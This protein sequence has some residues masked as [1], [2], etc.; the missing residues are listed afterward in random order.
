MGVG[1]YI[2]GYVELTQDVQ[3]SAA[4]V[5]HDLKFILL[6]ECFTSLTMHTLCLLV[7]YVKL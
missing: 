2:V 6:R 4:M 3:L 7:T 1:C 5:R